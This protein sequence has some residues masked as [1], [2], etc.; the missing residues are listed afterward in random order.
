MEDRY[1]MLHPSEKKKA[2]AWMAKHREK[3]PAASFITRMSVSGYG[4]RVKVVCQT[5]GTREDV[6]DEAKRDP[7]PHR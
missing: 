4:Y 1:D 2:D 6:S 7:Y 3:D 5:C